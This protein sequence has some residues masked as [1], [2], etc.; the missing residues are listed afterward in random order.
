MPNQILKLSDI[1]EIFRQQTLL[2][3]NLSDNSANA[4]RVR[5]SWPTDGQPG[6][7]YDEDII[8]L[9]ITD[10]NSSINKQI[11]TQYSPLSTDKVNR[12]SGYTRVHEIHWIIYGPNSYEDAERIKYGFYD[13]EIKTNLAYNNLFMV[14]DNETPIRLPELS[15]GKWYQRVDYTVRFNEYIQHEKQ[16]P[17][18][19]GINIKLY[20]EKGEIL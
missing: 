17:Y 5:I 2:I 4:G 3:L 18:I 12:I 13:E 7:D 14:L 1:E 19:Q 20:D 16:I 8:F 11:D 6:W 9:R 10:I 15:N